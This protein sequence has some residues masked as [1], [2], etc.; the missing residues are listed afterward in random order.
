MIYNTL[1]IFFLLEIKEPG[2]WFLPIRIQEAVAANRQQRPPVFFLYLIYY[3]LQLH[4]S[5]AYDCYVAGIYYNLDKAAGTATVTYYSRDLPSNSYAYTGN[6]VIPSTFNY[7]GITYSVTSIG[8]SAFSGCTGL[9]SITIPSSVT[10]IGNGAFSGCTGLTSIEI[11]NS[12]TSIG[13]GAFNGW[14]H[15][16]W[17]ILNQWP[18]SILKF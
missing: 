4:A 13:N 17:K 16:Y 15:N 7:D 2:F 1:Y 18:T 9:T 5:L 14:K 10:S 6:V 8:S 3:V 12:V 11:P